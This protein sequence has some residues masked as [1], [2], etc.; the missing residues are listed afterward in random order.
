[1][2]NLAET[3]PEFVQLDQR[4]NKV[5]RGYQAIRSTSRILAIA[6]G[7]SLF[8]MAIPVVGMILLSFGYAVVPGIFVCY[9]VALAFVIKHG[10]IMKDYA[11]ALERTGEEPTGM[12]LRGQAGYKQAKRK[13]IQLGL[14]AVSPV[15]VFVLLAALII[16]THMHH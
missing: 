10:R 16:A 6:F 8:A 9:F 2:T 14:A 15:V 11:L 1:M 7:A 13:A 3:S 4:L 5:F 12:Y